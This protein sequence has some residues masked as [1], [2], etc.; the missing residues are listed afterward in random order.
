ME[1]PGQQEGSQEPC[2]NCHKLC[3][4]IWGKDV[5]LDTKGALHLGDREMNCCGFLRR[6]L[7]K[8]QSLQSRSGLTLC[9]DEG[10]DC[11]LCNIMIRITES[12]KFRKE[13]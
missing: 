11:V 3:I 13:L 12:Q 10:L 7:L 4:A 9:R 5:L 1:L 6:D 2:T 8:K